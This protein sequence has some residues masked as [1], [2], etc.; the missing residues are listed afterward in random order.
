MSAP[1]WLCSV[2]CVVLY[3]VLCALPLVGCAS[4]ASRGYVF[5]SSYRDDIKTIAVPVFE[6][7]TYSHGIEI[8]LT[9]AIIKEIHR[10]TPWRVASESGADTALRGSIT[11]TELNRLTTGQQT[12]LVQ[13][14]AFEL[15]VSFEWK[16][17]RTGR[18]LVARRNFR[19]SGTFVA[20]QP[21][22]ERIDTGE[23]GAV[24]RLAR[25][26]VAELRS[27]W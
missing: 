24:D 16:E 22:G 19:S 21:A 12:G 10:S 5:S 11:D 20:A 6:N 4:E 27:S 14:M 8:D 2:L 18:V 15:T 1:R 23:R 17:S 25:D 7:V 13:E 3:M 26:I 9:D